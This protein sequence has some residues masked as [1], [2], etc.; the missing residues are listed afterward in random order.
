MPIALRPEANLVLFTRVNFA[1]RPIYQIGVSFFKI[2]LL[3]SYLRLFKG[4]NQMTYRRLVWGC[5]VLVFAAHLA[6]TF[7]LVFAC[8]P[9]RLSNSRLPIRQGFLRY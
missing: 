8:S 4:T 7:A 5:I 1:G 3:V 9:V 6:C 2:A